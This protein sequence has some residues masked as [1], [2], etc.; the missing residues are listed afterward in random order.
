[1]PEI[2]GLALAAEFRDPAQKEN[3]TPMVRIFQVR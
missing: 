3:E 1:V 2:S